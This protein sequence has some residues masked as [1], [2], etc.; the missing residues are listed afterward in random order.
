MVFIGHK[1]TTELF[2]LDGKRGERGGEGG[3]GKEEE[4][5]EEGEGRGGRL[6][7][8]HLAIK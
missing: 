8:V 2:L 7:W 4:G 1:E 6:A 5:R 3:E